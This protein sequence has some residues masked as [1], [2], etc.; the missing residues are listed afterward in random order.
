M[1][2]FLRSRGMTKG[3]T[4]GLATL[5]LI[6]GMA[7]SASAGSLIFKDNFNRGY[8]WYGHSNNVGNHWK[9]TERHYNDVAISHNHLQLRD[10]RYDYTFNHQTYRYDYS[11]IDASATRWIDT[12]GFE[13]VYLMYD[14]KPLYGS[15]KWDYLHVDF[16]TLGSDTWTNLASHNLGGNPYRWTWNTEYFGSYADDTKLQLRFWTDVSEKYYHNTYFG[17][18]YHYPG[19][20]EGAYI[21]AVKI[22]GDPKVTPTPEP[23]S[24]ALLATGMVGMGLWRMRRNKTEQS[25]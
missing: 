19:A 16:R 24:M 22:W 18:H 13:N 12:T 5:M 7:S 23:S 10:A 6:G 8:G 4:A 11:P 1:S 21:D 2:I 3:L 17:G 20:N 25:A 9:E 15:D 14:F